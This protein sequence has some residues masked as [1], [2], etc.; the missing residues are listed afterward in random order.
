ML[1]KPV[2]VRVKC[3]LCSGNG[4]HNRKE[5]CY[6]NGQGYVDRWMD[7]DKLTQDE[8]Q[9]EQISNPMVEISSTDKT[10]TITL[11]EDITSKLK[12][13]AMFNETTHEQLVHT[14][15]ENEWRW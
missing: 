12:D 15:I 8:K 11:P 14:L 13:L 2:Q 10:L 6:C 7:T 9:L 4:K 3:P 5:C 1:N